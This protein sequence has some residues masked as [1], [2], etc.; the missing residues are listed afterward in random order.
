M[1]AA[2]A[3]AVAAAAA[4]PPTDLQIVL[5]WIGFRVNQVAAVEAELVDLQAV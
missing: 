4:A 3:P 2:V 1:A 5:G